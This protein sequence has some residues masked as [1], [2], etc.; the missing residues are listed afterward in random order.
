[1]QIIYVPNVSVNEDEVKLI[2][3]P[4]SVGTYVKKNE[5]ICEVET[6]KS[7]FDVEAESDGYLYYLHKEGEM[8]KIGSSLA[9]IT[10]KEEND[11]PS[12]FKNISKDHN[13]NSEPDAGALIKKFTKK[14]ELLA[15]KYGIRIEDIN[16]SESLITE[17]IINQFINKVNFVS[18]VDQNK[19]NPSENIDDLVDDVHSVNKQERVLILGAGGGCNLVLD[20]LARI[21]HQR[22]A[23]ILDNNNKVHNKSL[24]GTK[25]LGGF[26]LIE[27]L[28]ASGKFD[29]VISTIV[30][31]NEERAQIFYDITK[32]KIPFTNII[33]ATANIRLN[34]KIG[35]GNLIVS[36]C[37]LAPSLTLGDN[38]FLAAYTAIEHH[39]VV[40]S[41]CTFGPRFTASGKVEIGDKCKFGTG[42]FV[43]PMI[44][45]GENTT[46]ASGAIVTNHIPANSIVKTENRLHIRSKLKI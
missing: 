32:R 1:M 13:L 34:V 3:W 39:S 16:S 26:D 9:V 40:G 38:N 44:K 36:G 41:H 8:L 6:T 18:Q 20:I 30:R 10:E 15:K 5:I 29:A 31:D 42:V 19:K 27:E 24:M 37:Y 12:L 7:T 45:I 14:A 35:T 17:D 25:I 23:F 22:P 46:V 33:D 4:K 11:L 28:W 21:V 43:E 2:T